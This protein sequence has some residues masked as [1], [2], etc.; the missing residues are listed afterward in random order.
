MRKTVS[1]MLAV[2]L[3][4]A[5]TACGDN[6]EAQDLPTP[7]ATGSVSGDVQA[8]DPPQEDTQAELLYARFGGEEAYPLYLEDNQTAK[9]IANHVGT[10]DWNLPIYHYDDFEGSD[11]MQYYDIP[12]RYEIT[13]LSET[14]TEE[15]AGEVY[16]S[17]PNRII[18]FYGDATVEGD[19]TLVG[20]FDATEEFINAVVNNPVVE[21]WGN[22]IISISAAE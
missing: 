12:S 22:K 2:V 18:L 1:F 7:E 3:M 19:Y 10:A 16:Y 9:D 17:E 11:V 6:K 21:G 14:V 5:L 13:N 8:S 15:K 20:H 4:L